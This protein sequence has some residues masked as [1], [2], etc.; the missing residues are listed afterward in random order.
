MALY[1]RESLKRI[2]DQIAAEELGWQAGRNSLFGLSDAELAR[3]LGFMPGPEDEHLTVRI[4]RAEQQRKSRRRVA[5]APAAAPSSFNWQNTTVGGVTGNWTD[6]IGDQGSCGSCVAF[7]VG[8]TLGSRAAVTMNQ[9]PDQSGPPLLSPAYLFYCIAEAQDGMNCATGWWPSSAL[10]ACV[11]TGPGQG[12]VPLWSY[13]PYTACDQSCVVTIPWQGFGCTSSQ[14]F[15]D[16]DDMKAYISGTGPLVGTFIVYSDF[17]AYQ[18]GVY[19]PLS[20]AYAVGGHCINVV[21]YDDGT[22][23]WI[24]NNSWGTGWGM[25]GSFEIAYGVCDIDDSM[26]SADGI[27]QALS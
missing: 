2:T 17:F 19:S 12:G 16:T 9:L 5:P 7:G 11:S 15:T 22:G 21:G 4:A 20:T 1:D 24:C 27:V 26:L 18:S 8:G 6:P 3:R 25:S 14:T 23:A 13:F 10:A